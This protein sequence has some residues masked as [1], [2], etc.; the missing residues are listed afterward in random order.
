MENTSTGQKPI[1]MPIAIWILFLVI[2]WAG[3]S[4]VIK[5]IV[6]DMPSAWAA[7]LRFGLAY[8]FIVA[9]ILWQ[10]PVL[11]ISIQNLLLCSSIGAMT[12]LQIM[13]FNVGSQYTTGGRVTLLIFTYPLIVPFI[14]HFMLKNEP[15]EKKVVIGSIIAFI[16]LLVPLY[17]SLANNTPT[18]KGDLLELSS[19]IVLSFLIVTTKYAFSK[20]NKWTV[21]FWQSTANLL[22]FGVNAMLTSGFEISS[23]G[24]AAWS[25]LAFQVFVVTVFAFLSYQ[26][27]LSKHNSS[28][29]AVFFFATPLFGMILGGI[30]HNEAFELALFIGCVSVGIGIYIANAPRMSKLKKKGKV[31]NLNNCC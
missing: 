1:T 25:S 5:F 22:F 3:N 31:P 23:I 10:K 18:L 20:M 30:L 17:D 6:A 9:F 14:A 7:F 2:F 4:V 21:F 12:F 19:S 28:K 24:K 13:L 11:K 15:L 8:P 27:I 26:Y 16:G 29:V